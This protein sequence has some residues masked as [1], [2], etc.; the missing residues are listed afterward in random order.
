LIALH[1]ETHIEP[2]FASQ[3]E[4]IGVRRQ[5]KLAGD[6]LGTG[7]VEAHLEDGR[8]LSQHG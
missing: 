6:S 2:L 7:D 1:F 4:D 3:H 5:Q 8:M